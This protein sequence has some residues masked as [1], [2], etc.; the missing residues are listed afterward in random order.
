[1]YKSLRLSV[2]TRILD[3][4]ALLR[5]V[6][7]KGVET[8]RSYSGTVEKESQS[9]TVIEPFSDFM[10]SRFQQARRT[11]LVEVHTLEFYNRLVAFCTK[12]VP[13]ENIFLGENGYGRRKMALIEMKDDEARNAFL[14]VIVDNKFGQKILS[15]FLAANSKKLP[16]LSP[17]DQEKFMKPEKII[18]LKPIKAFNWK[19][20][21]ANSIFWNFYYQH[22]INEMSLRLRF[23][24]A[25]QFQNVL[26][27]WLDN[28]DVFPFGGSINGFGEL[29]SD[30]DLSLIVNEYNWTRAVRLLTVPSERQEIFMLLSYLLKN[31]LPG[32]ERVDPR[33]K[34]KVPVIAFYHHHVDFNCDLS[35]NAPSCIRFSEVLYIIGNNY[36]LVRPMVMVIKNWARTVKLNLP[37][38]PVREVSNF[39]FLSLIV[40]FLQQKRNGLK[41]TIPPFNIFP[42]GKNMFFTLHENESI[43]KII[44]DTRTSSDADEDR[45][46]DAIYKFFCFYA[47]LNFKLLGLSLWT[48]KF[49]ENHKC[50]PMYIENPFDPSANIARSMTERRVGKLKDYMRTA[51]E[52]YERNGRFTREFTSLIYD[53][54][55]SESEL[56]TDIID[57]YDLRMK[58]E[59]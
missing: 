57:N 48:G 1:M 14:D 42:T 41:E 55:Q 52:T 5:T 18:N 49:M 54:Q 56:Q 29:H 37:E 7:A 36:R 28:C 11:I 17:S 30:L 58:N 33:A 20:K 9:A 3:D 40:F 47:D 35:I 51:K 16:I 24:V 38:S 39:T 50:I 12:C 19:E 2:L 27:G 21:D 46:D 6:K 53:R 15:P 59:E 45:L 44:N 10:T 32:C 22:K 8:I 26:N 34:A 23:L 25:V 13:I 4:G 43:I 31:W